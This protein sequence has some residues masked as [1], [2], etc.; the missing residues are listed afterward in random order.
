MKGFKTVGFNVIMAVLYFAGVPDAVPEAQITET[1]TMVEAAFNG[2]WA[3]G[4]L[5]LRAITDS[6][7]FQ[8][9]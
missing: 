1:L 6:P 9:A 8:R 4:N 2:A 3:L 5:I 7:I